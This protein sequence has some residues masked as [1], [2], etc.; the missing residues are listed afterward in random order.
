MVAKAIEIGGYSGAGIKDG[1]HKVSETFV[2]ASGP[3]KFDDENYVTYSFDWVQ[4]QADGTLALV[5]Q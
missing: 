1:T 5:Q 2:G 3:K 4:W